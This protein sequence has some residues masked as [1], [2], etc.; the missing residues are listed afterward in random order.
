MSATP[1]AASSLSRRK[2]SI[3]AILFDKDGTLVDFQRTWGPAVHAVMLALA[4]GRRGTYERLAAVSGFVE[5]ERAFRPNSLLVAH[6]I[7]EW[8][9]LWAEAVGCD[10]SPAFLADVDQRLCAATSAH[11]VPIGDPAKLIAALVRRGCRTGVFSNDAETTVRAH[12]RTL[13]IESMLA[14]IAGYDSGFGSKPEPGPVRAFA[15]AAGVNAGRTAVVGDSVLDLAAAR[16]AG[17][18]AVGVLTGPAA[19]EVRR[20]DPDALL[21]SAECILEWLGEA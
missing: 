4:G 14:F 5:S 16:S 1:A 17:A 21:A 18:V 11:L 15:K 9:P 13:G 12:V 7:R 20:A 8:G 2:A 10:A 6:S 3:E 19:D